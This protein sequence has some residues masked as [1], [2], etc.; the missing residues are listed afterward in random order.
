[1]RIFAPFSLAPARLIFVPGT[2][3]RSPNVQIVTPFSSAS[4]I[5]SSINPTGVTQT[6]QPGPEINST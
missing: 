1:M 2:R 4:Q 5:A 6:G 3:T